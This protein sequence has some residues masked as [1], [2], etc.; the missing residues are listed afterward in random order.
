ML[1]EPT[2][3]ASAGGALV[4]TLEERGIDHRELFRRVGLD[5]ELMA[6]DGARYPFRRVCA[7][8]ELAVDITRDECRVNSPV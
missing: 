3:L 8:W 5:P 7:L 1:I 4:L 6:M 2:S